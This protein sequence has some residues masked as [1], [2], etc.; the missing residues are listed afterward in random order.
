MLELLPLT[1]M[2]FW[3]QPI[4]RLGHFQVAHPVYTQF[5]TFAMGFKVNAVDVL[6]ANFTLML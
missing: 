4:E 2:H 6:K 1:I 3:A 5:L